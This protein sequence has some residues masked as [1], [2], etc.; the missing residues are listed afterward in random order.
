MLL[1]PSP[2]NTIGVMLPGRAT[3]V[4]DPTCKRLPGLKDPIPTLPFLSTRKLV[5]LEDPITKLACPAGALTES[6]APGLVVPMP[7]LPALSIT[8]GDASLASSY[9]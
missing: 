3:N 9:A 8:K 4:D 7:T 6:N 1:P 2:A 5:A